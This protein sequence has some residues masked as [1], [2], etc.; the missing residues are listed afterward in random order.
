MK[1][2]RNQQR[3]SPEEDAELERLRLEGH[4]AV[5][6]SARLGRTHRSVNRRVEVLGLHK[7]HG[8]HPEHPLMP[9]PPGE[10]EYIIAHYGKGQK[11]IRQIAAD[12]GLTRD[13]VAN[14]AYRRG[15]CKPSRASRAS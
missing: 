3:G 8:L 10:D 6:I 14:R 5:I 4:Q 13:A 7:R 9:N 1:A 11:S 15:L 12:L 2:H